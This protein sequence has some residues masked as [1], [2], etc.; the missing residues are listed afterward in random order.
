MLFTGDAEKKVESELV[1]TAGT[2]LASDV[3]KAPHHGSKT[4][5]SPRYLKLIHPSLCVISCG[6]GNDYGHPHA[7]TLKKYHALK[8]KTYVT[9]DNG[10]ITI[11]SN[12]DGYQVSCEKGDAQ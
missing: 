6:E 4:S 10:T 3:L 12:G 9:K 11:T 7:E 2:G 8:A 1:Q 5:S